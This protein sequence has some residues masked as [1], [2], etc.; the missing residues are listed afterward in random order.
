MT[1]EY[2]DRIFKIYLLTNKCED[3]LIKETIDYI[4][5]LKIQYMKIFNESSTDIIDYHDHINY[6]IYFSYNKINNSITLSVK[7]FYKFFLMRNSQLTRIIYL[8]FKYI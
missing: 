4:D 2:I 8:Y 7:N 6:T 1:E 3:K 5:S